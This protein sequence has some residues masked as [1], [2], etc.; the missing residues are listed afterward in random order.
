MTTPRRFMLDKTTR[1]GWRVGAGCPILAR[2]LRKGGIPRKHAAEPSNQLNHHSLPHQRRCS[3][4]TRQRNIPF[5]VENAIHLRAACLQQDRHARLRRFFFIALVS[6]QATT[7]WMAC[8]CASSKMFSFFKKS[9]MLDPRFF[10]LTDPLLF[11]REFRREFFSLHRRI[12]LPDALQNAS[13]LG[14]I[15]GSALA[16]TVRLGEATC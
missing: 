4:Q 8:A 14:R 5:R 10:L 1:R 9:S 13:D 15:S 7:S 16:Q 12:S 3:L 2:F 11:S 6:C